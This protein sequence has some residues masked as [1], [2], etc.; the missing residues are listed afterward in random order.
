MASTCTMIGE[1][2]GHLVFIYPTEIR[3]R[4]FRFCFA[5]WKQIEMF[6]YFPGYGIK[7]STIDPEFLI[8]DTNLG[9]EGRGWFDAVLTMNIIEKLPTPNLQCKIEEYRNVADLK[10]IQENHEKCI[11]EE[12]HKNWSKRNESCN[13]FILNNYKYSM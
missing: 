12:F 4:L 7:M 6:V 11:I 13:P 3:S 9:R 8:R 1:N 2:G 10:R 5:A